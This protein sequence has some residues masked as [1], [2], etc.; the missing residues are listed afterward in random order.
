MNTVKLGVDIDSVLC[1]SIPSLLRRINHEQGTHFE[2]CDVIQ[3]DFPIGS[4]TFGD[5]ILEAFRDPSFLID[6]PAMDGAKE[7]MKRLAYDFDIVIVTSRKHLTV[8]ATKFWVEQR[9]GPLPVIHTG[10]TKNGHDL[11]ILIDDAPH[12]VMAFAN[13]GRPAILFDQPWNQKL[14]LHPLI[15][16]CGNWPA[17][18]R[19]IYAHALPAVLDKRHGYGTCNCVGCM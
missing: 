5:L 15:W 2:K 12:N 16:R 3:W 6:L 17:V 13:E 11:D 8:E 1:D 19:A 10:E 7:A 4:R 18:F 9:F 14:G